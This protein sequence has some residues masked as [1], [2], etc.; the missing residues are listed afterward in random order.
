M[1]DQGEAWYSLGLLLAE[2]ARYGDAAGSLSRAAALMPGRPRI[3]YNRALVLQQLGRNPEAEA[4]CAKPIDWT[5]GT[6]G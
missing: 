4:R 3:H 6:S 1:P 5:R 2:M